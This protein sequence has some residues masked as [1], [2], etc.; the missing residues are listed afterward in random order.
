MKDSVSWLQVLGI[1]VEKSTGFLS[2][3]SRTFYFVLSKIITSFGALNKP[4]I[5]S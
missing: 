1:K 2:T 4:K 3:K 5:I